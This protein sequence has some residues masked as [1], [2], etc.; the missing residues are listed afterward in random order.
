MEQPLDFNLFD[1]K[2]DQQTINY[3][4]ESARWG[5]FLAILGFVFCGLM[6]LMGVFFGSFMASMI[7][8]MNA[9]T[10]AFGGGFFSIFF[11]ISALITFFPSLFLYNFSS[12]MRK[13]VRNNDQAVMTESFKN[14]KSFFKYYGIFT[15]VI[16][17]F[18]A[19]AIISAIFGAMFGRH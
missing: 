5:R 14:L 9:E 7:S 11:V 12:K 6:V 15:I 4:N 19:L 10:A 8:G 1:L 2:I 16:L 17:S 3:L 18:Y 13:A